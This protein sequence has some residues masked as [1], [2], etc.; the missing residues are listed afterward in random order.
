[1]STYFIKN[2]QGDG[3][4]SILRLDQSRKISEPMNAPGVGNAES[5]D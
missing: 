4:R 3:Y 5:F 2:K 1:V